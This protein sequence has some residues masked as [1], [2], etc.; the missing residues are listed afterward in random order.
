MSEQ[1]VIPQADMP[2]PPPAPTEAALPPEIAYLKSHGFETEAGSL[3]TELESLLQA[4]EPAPVIAP[5]VAPNPPAIAEV[6]P[7]TAQE[8]ALDPYAPNAP[9]IAD[10]VEG[11]DVASVVIDE[12]GRARD[13]VTGKYVPIKALHQERA[14]AKEL[15]SELQQTR[16]QNARVEERL[17]ILN[18]ILSASDDK[19]KPAEAPAPIEE[20]TIDPEVDIFAAFKQLANRAKKL[21]KQITDTGQM[22]RAEIE[23]LRAQQ[24]IRSDVTGFNNRTPDFLPAYNHLRKTRDAAL[25]ALGFA[26]KADRDSQIANEERALAANAIKTKKSYAQTIYDLAQAYGYAKPAPEPDPTPVHAPTPPAPSPAVDPATAARVDALRT[27]KDQASPTLN[28]AGGSPAE[29]LTVQQLANMSEVDFLNLAG[30]LGKA[31]LDAL[32]RGT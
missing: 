9:R 1:I 7:Q 10:E 11:E 13:A 25:Q 3:Q 14:K 28:G 18:E 24:A 16:E 6:K 27:A 17:T 15:R 4:R 32:L 19:P 29:G 8:R 21:E 31:K 20:E 22:S 12:T 30:K 23:D 5:A 26:D 2:A